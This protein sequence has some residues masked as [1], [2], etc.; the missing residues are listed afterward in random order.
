[1]ATK[2]V[3]EID[4]PLQ[5]GMPLIIHIPRIASAAADSIL[6]YSRPL[7][8]GVE[9]RLSGIGGKRNQTQQLTSLMRLPRRFASLNTRATR[10]NLYFSCAAFSRRDRLAR[11]SGAS[12]SA[13]ANSRSARR[14]AP[15]T[16]SYHRRGRLHRFR[17]GAAPGRACIALAAAARVL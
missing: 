14:V 16:D 15:P 6:G 13:A 8:P 12:C 9:R 17:A 7:P 5:G 10:V 2:D 4:P 3:G 11:L 1:M